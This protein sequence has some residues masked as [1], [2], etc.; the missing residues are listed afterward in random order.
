[1][2]IN[3]FFFFKLK[4]NSSIT[5]PFFRVHQLKKNS[6]E[7]KSEKSFCC[8]LCRDGAM[9]YHGNHKELKSQNFICLQKQPEENSMD[10]PTGFLPVTKFE[11]E[12]SSHDFINDLYSDDDEGS[13]D[14]DNNGTEEKEKTYSSTEKSDVSVSL[15]LQEDRVEMLYEC[16]LCEENFASPFECYEHSKYHVSPNNYPC[17]VC[18]LSFVTEKKLKEHFGGHKNKVSSTRKTPYKPMLECG[19]CKFQFTTRKDFILHKC[20][21][22]ILRILQNNSVNLYCHSCDQHFKTLERAELH[23]AYHEGIEKL[24]CKHCEENF[25]TQKSLDYHIK[26]QHENQEPFV[27]QHCEFRFFSK[28]HFDKHK[29]VHELTTYQC[30]LCNK[31]FK[32]LEKI[33]SHIES[34]TVNNSENV[35]NLN[36]KCPKCELQFT[37]KAHYLYHLENFH[38]GE[39]NNLKRMP[40]LIQYQCKIC[41][42]RFTLSQDVIIHRTVHW[43][44]YDSCLPH[45]CEYCGEAHPSPNALA[46]HRRILHPDEQPYVCTICEEKTRTLYEARVHR[47]TH[48]GYVNTP[49]KPPSKIY[50][51]D[52]CPSLFSDKASF[53]SHK[54][55]HRVTKGF[56][57]EFC[58][59]VFPERH[60]LVVHRRQHTGEKPFSCG[61]CGK[62]FAQ[63]SAMYTH[64]LLHTGETP[65]SC[66]LCGRRFR[67]K[68]DRDNHRRTHTGEKPYKCPYCDKSF[69]TGQVYYQH[70]M[71]HTG[72]RR[73]P[74]DICGRAFKRSHT[75]VCHRRIHTGEKPNICD[76]CGKGFRQRTDM[77]KHKMNLHGVPA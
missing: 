14:L 67:I 38:D 74:C 58:Q 47:K 55:S 42:E 30:S 41:S 52:N 28:E 1:M 71:I 68:S 60:R 18:G 65:H 32:D 48:T 25:E 51:C 15:Y 66:D 62:K 2:L 22:P 8:P 64:A 37:K 45:V 29:K 20:S 72:E 34:H 19:A 23:R 26:Y 12:D 9:K 54:K 7:I 46:R 61:V 56:Q 77:R 59:K 17:L 33:T 50:I 4:R 44:S 11:P 76:V 10:I 53:L 70:R 57:C 43:K 3:F 39:M 35:S 5:V 73:F 36:L 49:Q 21:K 6:N 27:C 40:S 69:R 31:T 16:P 63:T 24:A 75:L 13:C